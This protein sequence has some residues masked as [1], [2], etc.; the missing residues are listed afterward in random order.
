MED[1]QKC[2]NHGDAAGEGGAGEGGARRVEGTARSRKLDGSPSPPEL[3]LMS[4]FIQF[5]ELG[6]SSHFI[7]ILL[8]LAAL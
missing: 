2:I 1:T 5:H 8:R 6:E 3:G 7:T 4:Y